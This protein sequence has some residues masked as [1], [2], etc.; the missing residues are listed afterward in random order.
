MSDDK[1]QENKTARSG[2]PGR[3]PPAT[4]HNPLII[5]ADANE[6]DLE[7]VKTV[8]EEEGC[9]VK[10]APD[11]NALIRGMDA[12]NP[13]LV[14]VDKDLPGITLSALCRKA[15]QRNIAVI[16]L[17]CF[18]SPDELL[19]I[20]KLGVLEVV[21]K[22]PSPEVVMQKILRALAYAKRVLKRE[23]EAPAATGEN[24]NIEDKVKKILTAA[25]EVKTIPHVAARLIA[26]CGK[27]DTDA[28]EIAKTASSDS[29]VSLMLLRRANSAAYGG[30]AQAKSL[31]EA[32]VRIGYRTI[33]SIVA[34]A[35]VYKMSDTRNAGGFS[36][37]GHWT[38]SL[39]VGVLAELM[40]AKMQVPDPEDAFLAG[41]LHDFGKLIFDDYMQADYAMALSAAAS[42]NISIHQAELEYFKTGHDAIGWELCKRWR[43]PEAIGEAVRLHHDDTGI[44]TDDDDSRGKTLARFVR[45]ADHAARALLLG[46]SG[47]M[48]CPPIYDK[49]WQKTGPSNTDLREFNSNAV[50][51]V[52]EMAKCMGITSDKID[53]PTP[54][55]PK[56]ESIAIMDSGEPDRLLDLFA[57]SL[58]YDVSHGEAGSPVKKEPALIIWDFREQSVQ[59]ETIHDSWRN[60]SGAPLVVLADSRQ[61]KA[62]LPE[63]ST[64]L[65]APVDFLALSQAV[66][67]KEKQ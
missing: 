50:T 60:T 15:Q 10:P 56:E 48:R 17:G 49:I 25:R 37:M 8:A 20:V 46:Y 6:K 23:I 32:I 40:A 14:F 5:V 35:S 47:E 13:I 44:W 33:R 28:D 52:N 3:K 12:M 55:L 21:T 27:A 1:N 22:P 38:H 42:K 26:L 29:S 54:P 36:R 43:M 62:A 64:I 58:G 59:P 7:I 53:I 31:R 16:M 57:A 63:K 2:T 18:G 39:S 30:M 65:P 45:I 24:S 41:V 11:M 61:D 51:R 34:I 67:K 19:A 4:I 9:D 66:T